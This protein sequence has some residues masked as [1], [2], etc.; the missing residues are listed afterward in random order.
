MA[1]IIGFKSAPLTVEEYSVFLSSAD[2]LLDERLLFGELIDEINEALSSSRHSIRL[3]LKEWETIS[4]FRSPS[5]VNKVIIQTALA[6]AHF[7]VGL[8]GQN[9]KPGT[10]EELEFALENNMDMCVLVLSTDLSP[11]VKKYL[12]HLKEHEVNV[13]NIARLKKSAPALLLRS[14]LPRTMDAMQ[15]QRTPYVEER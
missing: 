15:L 8:L 1:S 12:L 9:L 13:V 11:E 5:T 3:F 2:E 4:G 6:G 14:V 10:E 7:V